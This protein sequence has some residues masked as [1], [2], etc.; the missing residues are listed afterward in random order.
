[1]EITMRPMTVDEAWKHISSCYHTYHRD[2]KK[3]GYACRNFIPQ[4]MYELFNTPNLSEQDIKNC[5]DKFVKVYN[6]NVACLNRFDGVFESY[7]KPKL[8]SAINEF[9]TPLLLSWNATLPNKLEILCTFG[10]GASYDR[11]SDEEAIVYFRMSRYP[12]DKDAV[13]NA[14]FH[15][16]IHILIEKPIIQKYKVPQDLKE[17]I[18]DLIGY[19]FMKIPPQHQMFVNSFANAYITPETI[20]TDLPGAVE[21][22]MADYKMLQ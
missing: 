16:F 11:K 5:H 9:L 1:M 19:E 20:K 17:R 2:L 12:D 6:H 13:L 8:E 15:E 21:K 3:Y 22:M 7:V 18:V 4:P 10:R 14:L